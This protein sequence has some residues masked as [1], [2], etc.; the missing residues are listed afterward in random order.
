MALKATFE[1]VIDKVY[2]TTGNT[3]IMGDGFGQLTPYGILQRLLKTYERANIQEI[4]AKLLHL[5]NPMDRKLPVEVM[6][7]DID[8][9][10]RFLLANLANKMGL[11][12]VQL[13]THGLIKLSKTG[14]L[15]EKANERWNQKELHIRQQWMD[16][17]THF[18][19]E[20]ENTLSANGGTP[21][22]QE[23][24]GTGGANNAIED[25]GS[26]LVESIV[27][28][29][30][31]AT[32]AEGKVSD[33][34]SCLAVLEMGSQQPTPQMGYYA[35]QTAYGMMPGAPPPPTTINVTPAYHQP[36]QQTG[37]GKRNYNDNNCGGQRRR[38][39]NY[40]GSRN[41]SG[42]RGDRRNSNNTQKAYSNSFKQNMNLLY[43]FLCGYDVEY[44]GYN[45]LPNCQKQVHLTHVKRYDAHMYEDAC[46]KAKH[47]TMPD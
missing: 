7:R 16:F 4:E 28:Y 30:E 34:E 1:R 39:N 21:M 45:C 19:E 10:Q 17:K 32:T 12:D 36:Q 23:G 5:N 47:K 38:P 40:R 8:D 2:H 27:Q 43:C 35:P 41:G 14:G 42:D 3:G 29:L 44:D 18:I 13:C 9:V 24:Y 20:Y 22:V 31:R 15:Y 33:L 46:M 6:I 25:D 26:S 37:G 11:T